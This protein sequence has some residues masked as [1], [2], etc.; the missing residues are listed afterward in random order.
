MKME[1]FLILKGMERETIKYKIPSNSE[2]ITAF[3]DDIALGKKPNQRE[4]KVYKALDVSSG[5]LEAKIWRR[6][7]NGIYV[8]L[9]S[10][11]NKELI[12]EYLNFNATSNSVFFKDEWLEL[13]EQKIEEKQNEA[14]Q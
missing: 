7:A 14:R 1:P 2:C 11:S 10:L 12:Q 5:L 13:F 3:K 6:M 9:D 4:Y 8:S